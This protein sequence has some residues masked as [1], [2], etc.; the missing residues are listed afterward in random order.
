MMKKNL[1]K[2]LTTMV[3][4]VAMVATMVTGFS[5]DVNG[6]TTWKKYEGHGVKLWY[7]EAVVMVMFLDLGDYVLITCQDYDNCEEHGQFEY[8]E[9]FGGWVDKITCPHIV[10]KDPN[11]SSTPASTPTKKSEN[12]KS[13]PKYVAPKEENPAFT[14]PDRVKL[15]SI[16]PTK[17]VTTLN[18]GL[19]DDLK[20]LAASD[21]T[22]A[23]QALLVNNFATT[24][25]KKARILVSDSLY[26]NRMLGADNGKTRT[27]KWANLEKTPQIVYALCYNQT[28]K[29]YFIQGILDKD[30]TSTFNDFILRDMTNITI[31]VLE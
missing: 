19:V 24:A 21:T 14:H 5:I 12:K 26:S 9:N 27:L 20:V 7:D 11:G 2:R 10:T 1:L 4:A 28:D 3:V 18:G 23:N 6:S 15:M 13:E 30:G 29:A 16:L 8:N 17:T 22:K 31:F 25:G